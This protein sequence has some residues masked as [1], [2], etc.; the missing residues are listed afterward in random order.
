MK[1][2]LSL[3][4]ISARVRKRKNKM[5]LLCVIFA[6]FLVTAVFSMAEMGLRMEKAR[7]VEK[8]GALS[9][10]DI[11]SSEMGQSLFLIAAVSTV[12]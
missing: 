2:Y 5:T 10:Q 3:I 11:S 9:V 4:P 1:S 6:V 8:H 7:L 12:M